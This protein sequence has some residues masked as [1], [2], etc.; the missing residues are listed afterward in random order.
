[1][2]RGDLTASAEYDSFDRNG[3]GIDREPAAALSAQETEA[4]A[5]RW[6]LEAQIA[7]NTQQVKADMDERQSSLMASSGSA[8]CL[9]TLNVS[10]EDFLPQTFLGALKVRL[11]VQQLSLVGLVPG[12]VNAT[13]EIVDVQSVLL[14]ALQTA[15]TLTGETIGG[16]MVLNVHTRFSG[17]SPQGNLVSQASTIPGRRLDQ[18]LECQSPSTRVAALQAVEDMVHKQR[19][20]VRE[21]IRQRAEGTRS[22]GQSDTINHGSP[23]RAA[24][25]L[26]KAREGLLEAQA[27]IAAAAI[28]NEQESKHVALEQQAQKLRADDLEEVLQYSRAD[29]YSEHAKATGVQPS[30]MQA[31]LAQEMRS[32]K[33][34]IRDEVL[35]NNTQRAAVAAERVWDLLVQ[36]RVRSQ[37]AEVRASAAERE[38]SVAR[39]ESEETSA[40]HLGAMKRVRHL[41]DELKKSQVEVMRLVMRAHSTV[42]APTGQQGL[43]GLS[44]NPAASAVQAAVGPA[45]NAAIQQTEQDANTAASQ[46]SFYP[47]NSVYLIILN[48]AGEL[49]AKQFASKLQLNIKKGLIVREP[50]HWPGYREDID[51]EVAHPWPEGWT[52]GDNGWRCVAA[53]VLAEPMRKPEVME[54]VQIAMPQDFQRLEVRPRKLLCNCLRTISTASLHKSESFIDSSPVRLGLME[55]DFDADGA[56]AQEVVQLSKTKKQLDLLLNNAQS[57]LDAAHI[58]DIEE[59]EVQLQSK[60]KQCEELRLHIS[61]LDQRLETLYKECEQYATTAADA[62]AAREVEAAAWAAEKTQLELALHAKDDELDIVMVGQR[63]MAQDKDELKKQLSDQN[64]RLAQCEVELT[65]GTQRCQATELVLEDAKEVNARWVEHMQ[66]LEEE[67]NTFEGLCEELAVQVEALTEEVEAHRTRADDTGKALHAA[68]QLLEAEHTNSNTEKARLEGKLESML[69]LEGQFSSLKGVN[70][71]LRTELKDREQGNTWWQSHAAQLEIEKTSLQQENEIMRDMLRGRAP[72][73]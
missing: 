72:H 26:A 4:A 6:K 27:E 3:D 67:R 71:K 20:R 9:F 48:Q 28:K 17:G 18:S 31:Q 11:R 42:E 61:Q 38:A 69:W 62:M 12:S 15:N 54:K 16:Y 43:Y 10:L 49:T 55:C 39:R 58:G 30:G 63:R 8:R 70:E 33:H 47:K 52:I 36:E 14:S 37:Q 22:P 13:V 25:L 44:D 35:S 5:A 45:L 65:Q 73:R 34:Q 24:G 68:N 60:T 7:A 2:T 53:V 32:G 23:S 46:G 59:L 64:H 57:N 56:P 41:E 21:E 29:E 1:M 40:R 50:H 51:T 66:I 19:E